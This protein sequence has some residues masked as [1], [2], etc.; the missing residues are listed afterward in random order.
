MTQLQLRL[1]V[2]PLLGSGHFSGAEGKLVHDFG[3]RHRREQPIGCG[4]RQ[5]E[6]RVGG[7]GRV[8]L[9]DLAQEGA[10]VG[11]HQAAS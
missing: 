5:K 1:T 10:E 9:G 2:T 6:S 4:L 11:R 3:V 7:D 8:G